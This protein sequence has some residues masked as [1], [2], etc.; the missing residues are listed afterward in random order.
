[1]QSNDQ[2][3]YLKQQSVQKPLSRRDFMRVLTLAGAAGPGLLT[4]GLSGFA[5]TK[6]QR[7]EAAEALVAGLGTLPKR[8][9]GSR[10][11]DMKVT[12]ICICSDWNPELYAPA[13]AAG[14]NFVHKAGYWRSMPPEFQ[15]LPRES[16]YVDTT[17]DTTSPGH[18][19]DDFDAAYNQVISELDK[20]GLKY[21]DIYRAHY[22]W[23]SVDAI[24]KNN[25][26]YKVFQRLKREGK[27]RHFGVSQHA[28]N[29]D[30]SQ[31]YPT[32]PESMQAFIDIGVIESIQC[33]FAYGYPKEVQE[34]FANASK[35]GI[36]MTAMK[37]FATGNGR[38]RNDPARMAALKADGM[39]G[40]ACMRQVLTTHRSDGKPIFQTC[41]SAL[42]NLQTFEENVGAAS[43][44]ITM[45][46]GFDLFA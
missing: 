24:K 15:K 2:L 38:M 5:L 6:S 7:A 12:P 20:T 27:V 42:R 19:P 9:L 41:V 16:Y 40:R 11:G 35:A 13:I 8:K 21:F 44:N 36:G 23:H 37:V 3:D 25:V 29:F 17:V 22:G 43:Q 18:N 45:R 33:W 46:D 30:D 28:K 32:Y 1:M 10:M 31:P 4:A 39:V 26:S 34:A 14:I